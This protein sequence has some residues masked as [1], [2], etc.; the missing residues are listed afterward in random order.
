MSG[1]NGDIDWNELERELFE[2][3]GVEL[4]RRRARGI[5]AEADRIVSMI[6][7]PDMPR[8]DIEIAIR[9]FRRRVLEEFPGR[10]ELFDAIYASRFRRVWDQFRKDG[11]RL[12]GN[13]G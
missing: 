8:V 7:R 13:C 10:E 3:A 4:D 5:R 12:P 9:S 2:S 11:G 1:K 6:L